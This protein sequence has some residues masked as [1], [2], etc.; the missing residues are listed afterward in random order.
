MPQAVIFDYGVGNLLSLKTALE[1]AGLNRVNRHH[2]QK[3]WQKPT[4]S[5]CRVLEASPPHPTNSTQSK[6][7]FKPKSKKAPHC[8]AFAWVCSF[9]LNPAKKDQEQD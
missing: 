4:Q 2:S 9:S 5:H 6:K 3:T 8:L 1:K 7:P